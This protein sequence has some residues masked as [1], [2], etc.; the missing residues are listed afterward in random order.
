MIYASQEGLSTM[1]ENVTV[2]HLQAART[3]TQEEVDER[4]AK[5]AAEKVAAVT[6]Y[7][8]AT[9]HEQSHALPTHTS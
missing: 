6:R 3:L 9:G 2:A 5:R 1:F 7:E 8:S 4:A